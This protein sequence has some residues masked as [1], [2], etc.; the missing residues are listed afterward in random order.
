[1]TNNQ[2]L[3][4][5]KFK[6]TPIT[7][8]KLIEYLLGLSQHTRYLVAIAGTPA[9]GKTTLAYSLVKKLNRHTKNQAALL[10]MDGFHYDNEVL[11]G[12][13][14]LSVKGAPQTFDTGGFHHALT[15]LR[16]NKEE[17]VTVPVFNRNHETAHAG[18]C[19]IKQQTQFIIV[20]GNYLLLNKPDWLAMLDLYDVSVMLKVPSETLRQRLHD[21]WVQQ[22]YTPEQI[23]KK[24]NETD[25]PNARLIMKQSVAA[26]FEIENV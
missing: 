5:N 18:A 20:E 21:R 8:K 23:E 7:K 14:L 13:N 9:S 4:L 16:Y 25:L 17:Q 11:K 12:L 10:Q 3:E 2:Q 24:L 1:M 19:I 6:S 22:N 15:R 26:N